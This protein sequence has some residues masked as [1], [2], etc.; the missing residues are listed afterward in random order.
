[1]LDG[2]LDEFVGRGEVA[3]VSAARK[4]LEQYPTVEQQEAQIKTTFEKS[5][6]F[7]RFSQDQARLGW[8]DRPEKRQT[9]VGIQG[10]NKPDDPAVATLLPFIRKTSTITDKDIRPLGEP[11]RIYFVQEAGAF[12]L[13]LLEGISRMRSLYRAV[14]AAERNPLHTAADEA[15]FRDLLPAGEDEVQVRRNVFLGRALGLIALAENRLSGYTEARL[16]HA[17]RQTGI[18][19][20]EAIGSDWQDAIQFL[21]NDANRRLRDL[22][23]DE[24]ARIGRAPA[25]RP[26]RQ[27]FYLR[28]MQHLEN[29]RGSLEGG[30]DNP[31]YR[32]V[33][34]AVEDYVRTHNL[35]VE[36]TVLRSSAPVP[37]TPAVPTPSA[38]EPALDTILD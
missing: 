4:F 27:E 8:E 18:E 36:G 34:A 19:K 21:A 5:E 38:E 16:R 12:P 37:A 7:L 10:G 25:T 17:D 22:L 1:M 23:A 11:Q 15:R 26:A 6:V 20:T 32:E 28:L 35:Y 30:E 33:Q 9:L 13:R 2:A 24:L 29:L 31:E 3:R 14:K